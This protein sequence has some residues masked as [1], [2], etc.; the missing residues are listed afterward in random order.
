M[1]ERKEVVTQNS[2]AFIQ[3]DRTFHELSEHAGKSD[4]VDLSQVFHVD[5]N[6]RW[7]DILKQP[8]TVILSEAG[9]GKTEEI[10]NA[11]TALR[12]EG[13]A[14]FFARLELL[15]DDFD[16]AFEIGSA[17]EFDAWLSSDEPGWILLDSVDEARL[18]S[19]K[20]FERAIR[21]TGVALKNA[22]DRAVIVLT[23][24][25]HAWRAKTDLDLCERHIGAPP[26]FRVPASERTAEVTLP[27]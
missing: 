3:L 25:T 7:G 2:E 4:D 18:G 9:S 21:R 26:Q 10:K 14:A 17:S 5:T 16:F 23:G 19:P 1:H 8:R 20:D 11:T 13:K 22:K 12:R 15:A 24:R 6:L 27:L